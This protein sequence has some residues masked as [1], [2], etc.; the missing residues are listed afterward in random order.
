MG[1]TGGA[2]TGVREGD[3]GAPWG[4]RKQ[5]RVNMEG[6]GKEGPPL[7]WESIKGMPDVEDE[8]E[9]QSSDGREP[10]CR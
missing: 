4:Q 10:T 3:E 2:G 5:A 1:G 8:E 9:E 7:R 6:W